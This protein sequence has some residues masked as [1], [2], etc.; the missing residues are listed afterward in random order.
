MKVSV[1]VEPQAQ[2]EMKHPQEE[3]VEQEHE[4]YRLS[5]KCTRSPLDVLRALKLGM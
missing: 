2:V 4:E 1:D 5:G 3:P